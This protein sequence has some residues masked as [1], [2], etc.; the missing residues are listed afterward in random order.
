[1]YKKLLL[2][3]AVALCTSL[4]AQALD[5][6]YQFA[7]G[8]ATV[9]G[10]LHNKDWKRDRTA[11]IPD[12][13]EHN[14]EMVPV[15]V[16]GDRAFQD[17]TL[18]YVRIPYG[19][20]TIAYSAFSGSTICQMDYMARNAS[21]S[22][23]W[24]PFQ[25]AEIYSLTIGPLVES[26]VVLCSTKGVSCRIL[27]SIWYP[28]TV[29]AAFQWIEGEKYV[30]SS[31][32]RTGASGTMR[33]MPF[34]SSIFEVN[35]IKYVPNPSERTCEAIDCDYRTPH[36]ISI[37]DS[38]KYK[39]IDLN[40]VRI[41][42][43]L[44]YDNDS[45]KSIFI[46]TDSLDIPEYAFYGCSISNSNYIKVFCGKNIGKEAFSFTSGGGV[47]IDCGGDIGERA[48]YFCEESGL[49]VKCMGTIKTSAFSCN[50]AYSIWVQCE[51]N[52]GRAAFSN[53][54]KANNIHIKCGGSLD[55]RAFSQVSAKFIEA[56]CKAIGIEGFSK[57]SVERIEISDNCDSIGDYAF[58]G[59]SL[60]ANFVV[61][62]SVTFLGEGV[63][64]DCKA[65]KGIK[66]GKGL[67]ELPHK[68]FY[69]CSSLENLEIPSNVRYVY[70]ALDECSSLANINITD[71][72]STLYIYTNHPLFQSCAL[73][74]VYI[75]RNLDFGDT[76]GP[77][78]P[79]PFYCNKS[80]RDLT[81]HG[82]NSSIIDNMFAGCT[83][84]R[85][86]TLDE[87]FLRIEGEALYGCTSLTSFA[88][89]NSVKVL[90]D[91]VWRSCTSLKEINLGNGITQIPLY[92]F[93]ECSSLETLN[94]PGNVT[95]ILQSLQG[96]KALA[97]VRMADG[98]STLTITT[99]LP[100]FNDCPLD[101]V[102]IGRNLQYSITQDNQS[103]FYRN[104]SLQSVTYNSQETNITANMFYGCTNLKT[105]V[106]GDGIETIA[107]RAFSLCTSLKTFTFGTKVKS[108]G[109]EAFSDCTVMTSLTALAAL[110]PTCGS[111]A[112]D[113]IV[114]WDC[115]LY[116]PQSSMDLYKSAPQW[117]EFFF[118]KPYE[119]S[120]APFIREDGEEEHPLY[121]D[122]R[123]VRVTRPSVGQIYLK[124]FKDKTVK[125]KF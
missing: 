19:I 57:C 15:K 116:V 31:L 100:L 27:K 118:I 67:T 60:L 90:G 43:W 93:N 79:S 82:H 71:G 96:C 49:D 64:Q 78:N 101:D 124:A 16:I 104:T 83:N 17:M 7:N 25:G 36:D 21:R 76:A 10:F 109:E 105:V 1:M 69:G 113:D 12:S 86:V 95:T 89:P 14:G 42:P 44:C 18:N 72:D 85:S 23:S 48:F 33:I 40:L 77:S 45:I 41:N 11:S 66:L 28:N 37:T 59:C 107:D 117:K 4:L 29:P 75:G 111:Q 114:K 94:I 125:V 55:E 34:V 102:Y 92:S 20:D 56:D 108:I 97:H 53:N 47:Y 22:V 80:L 54:N 110:P 39:G 2:L 63:W 62:D 123:G 87:G 5:L 122:L 70:Q 91:G 9:T 120:G 65:L 61:S 38:V 99:S 8:K 26:V 121:Y 103:P 98:D 46:R 35:G 6:T 106:L 13:V 3:T 119:S 74:R 115:T 73:D 58:N 50:S 68:S 30:P 52:I 112:L 81:Y 32:Y 84:L 24:E 51:G 88:V